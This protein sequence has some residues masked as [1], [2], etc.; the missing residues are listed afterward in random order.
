[1]IVRTATRGR[2]RTKG[3]FP[4]LRGRGEIMGINIYWNDL[5]PEKQRDIADSMEMAVADVARQTN[6]EL[7]PMAVVGIGED[8][9]E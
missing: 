8:G 7:M 4:R 5:T 3:L 2:I 6:W 1:M 9:E